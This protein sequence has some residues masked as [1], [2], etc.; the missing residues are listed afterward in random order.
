MTILQALVCFGCLIVG[1]L[2]G[3]VLPSFIHLYRIS[4][5]AYGKGYENGRTTYGALIRHAQAALN[6]PHVLAGPE[7][8]E[9]PVCRNCATQA[10]AI[11]R[12]CQ[13]GPVD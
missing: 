6:C 2:M 7:K 5:Y 11:L 13:I 10:R 12:R 9:A 1:A 4:Q 8:N 3:F